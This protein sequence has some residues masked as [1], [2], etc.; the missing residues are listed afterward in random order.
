MVLQVKVDKNGGNI[1]DAPKSNCKVSIAVAFHFI[2]SCDLWRPVPIS[3]GKKRLG[4]A[5]TG[6]SSRFEPPS[7][8]FSVS[9]LRERGRLFPHLG[10]E[11]NFEGNQA[12]R[13]RF[14]PGFE[15]PV[16]PETYWTTQ[17]SF[18]QSSVS[19]PWDKVHRLY[20]SQQ[21]KWVLPRNL[22]W[23]VGK[24]GPWKRYFLSIIAF[25]HQHSAFFNKKHT[26]RT[27]NSWQA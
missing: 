24:N 17:R 12:F 19:C 16:G 9:F 5:Q 7:F 26:D 23:I 18:F 14:S 8:F 10:I 4:I 20:H 11:D 15:V 25:F 2:K 3:L 27:R 13:S 6:V 21:G 22:T 1:H